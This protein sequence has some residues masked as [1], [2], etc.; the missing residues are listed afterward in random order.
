MEVSDVLEMFNKL[1]SSKLQGETNLCF[2]SEIHEKAFNAYLA[3]QKRSNLT[4]GW[5][6]LNCLKKQLR[7]N[8]SFTSLLRKES[9]LI[10]KSSLDSIDV[11][12][13]RTISPNG[14]RLIQV[15][16]P[17]DA[18]LNGDHDSGEVKV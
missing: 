8:E 12:F 18:S 11:H 9:L 13:L 16:T 15:E 2:S 1:A 7:C 3:D 6:L 10:E 5:D 17:L 4:D 14:L